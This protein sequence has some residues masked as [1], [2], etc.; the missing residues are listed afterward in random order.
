MRIGMTTAFLLLLAPSAM[1][2]EDARFTRD[3]LMQRALHRRAVEA[4][5]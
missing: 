2:Q 3:E 5:I 4:V 1:S